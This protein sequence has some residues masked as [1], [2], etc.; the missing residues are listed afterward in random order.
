[1]VLS[2]RYVFIFGARRRVRMRSFPSSFGTS[3]DGV[4]TVK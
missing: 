4:N 2:R 3:P 1:M